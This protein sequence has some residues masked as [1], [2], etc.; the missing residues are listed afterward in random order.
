MA[1]K[2]SPRDLILKMLAEKSVL[3]QDV[4]QKTKK[5]FADLKSTL[6]EINVDL[7]ASVKIYEKKLSLEY[8]EKGDYEVEYRIAGDSVIFMMHTNVFTFDREHNIWKS[9]YIEDDNSR[10]YCGVIYIYNFLADSLRYNRTSDVGYLIGRV[11]V[12]KD[13]H[14]FVEGKRQM[15]FLYNDFAHAVLDKANIRSVIES[16]ILYC[17]DF[18]LFSPGYES[19]KEISVQQMLESNFQQKIITGKRLGFRFQAD[20]DTV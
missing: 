17:L 18:D 20:D 1:K 15:G 13:L 2:E 3:K 16:A 14:F 9:S 8:F 10:S 7:K 4:F 12:N 19:V 5:I 6:K 11:F